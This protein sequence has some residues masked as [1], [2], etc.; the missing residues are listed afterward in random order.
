MDNSDLA[1]TG[2]TIAI[3]SSLLADD[4]LSFVNQNG[5]TGAYNAATGVLTLTGAATVQQYQ[6]ALQSIT[7]ASSALDPSSDG[8]DPERTVTWTLSAGSTK[9]SAVTTTI[10]VVGPAVISGGGATAHYTQ[11]G[12]AAILDAGITIADPSSATLTGATVAVSAGFVA[13]DA[14][15]FLNAKGVFGSYNAQSGVLTLSGVASLA[16]YQAAL[17]SITFS[18]SAADVTNGGADPTRTIAWT[19]A[20]NTAT[21]SAVASTVDASVSA[22]SLGGAG[23]TGRYV[24]GG[25]PTRIDPAL[26]VADPS[27]ATLTGASVKISSGFLAGDLLN[28]VNQ[29]GITGSYNATSGV[30]TLSGTATLAAYQA[31]LESVAFSSTS[32]DPTKGAADPTRKISWSVA[33]GSQQSAA[34]TSTIDV[35]VGSP[36]LSGGGVSATFALG[37]SPVVADGALGVGDPSSPTLTGATVKISAGFQAGDKLS[38]TASGG[39]TGSY[40]ATTGVLALTGAASLAVYSAIL[41]FG[42]LFDDGVE[43]R[44][45]DIVIR[46]DGRRL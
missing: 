35:S 5:I 21:S 41:D 4:A 10:D 6:A 25:N 8:A 23:N 15:H 12:A 42:R 26:T 28:F 3:T 16:T 29:R 44:H 33:S 11:G 27:S 18:S 40:D 13:G 46:R 17:D 39:V 19:V 9:S 30:L 20:D 31:A 36:A 32:S 14:L 2:A 43:L 37:G 34:V 24:A 22:P 1:L 38:F 7:Y 45:S